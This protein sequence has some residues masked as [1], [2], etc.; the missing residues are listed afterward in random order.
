MGAGDGD[1]P[2]APRGSQCPAAVSADSVSGLPRGLAVPFPSFRILLLAGPLGGGRT[3]SP[4]EECAQD[5]EGGDCRRGR[6]GD[7][8]DT[9]FCAH[10]P[11]RRDLD[12]DLG[13]D[14][15]RPAL[16]ASEGGGWKDEGAGFVRV[17][18]HLYNLSA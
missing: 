14:I 11:A 3:R 18:A 4:L 12:L 10:P 15:E 5:G 17:N 9:R 16:T 8:D 13:R 6:S 1:P 2:G 7:A